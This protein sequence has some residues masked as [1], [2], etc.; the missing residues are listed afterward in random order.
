MF[1]ITSYPEAGL[2]GHNMT[3]KDRVAY[4]T[5]D[6]K[7]QL[8]SFKKNCFLRE[9]F[10]AKSKCFGSSLWPKSF[11]ELKIVLKPWDSC[12]KNIRPI[13]LFHCIHI[14]HLLCLPKQKNLAKLKECFKLSRW[15]L[16][17]YYHAWCITSLFPGQEPG[18]GIQAFPRTC[19]LLILSSLPSSQCT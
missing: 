15:C 6:E 17:I 8:Y 1:C 4:L 18:E 13:Y 14:L 16:K 11:R 5:L 2:P 19:D 10:K 3:S 7:V 12:N 9:I